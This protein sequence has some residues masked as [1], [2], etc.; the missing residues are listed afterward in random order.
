M[1]NLDGITTGVY[2]ATTI[3]GSE[4][5]LDLDR[6]R[7]MRTPA[8]RMDG[9]N[10][11]RRDG[12]WERLVAFARARVGSGM[13]LIVDLKWPDVF[14]TTRRSTEIVSIEP[15]RPDDATPTHADADAAE[16]P[17]REPRP[18]LDPR[19]NG[20]IGPFYNTDRVATYLGRS[21]STVRAMRRRGEILG[22]HSHPHGHLYPGLQFHNGK[23]VP[24]LVDVIRIL[25]DAEMTDLTICLWLHGALNNWHGRTATQMLIGS[26]ADIEEVLTAAQRDAEN[27]R[28]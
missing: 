8:M 10:P 28:H 27:R 5:V 20:V 23:P 24:R 25:R 9:F 16:S 19:W 17:Q 12:E 13:I 11:L 7:M 26:E 2:R 14:L 3:S 1:R 21:V 6:N 15:I 18:E 22:I 4:Y